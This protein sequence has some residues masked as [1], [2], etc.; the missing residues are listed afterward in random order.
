MDI[1]IEIVSTPIDGTCKWVTPESPV[2]FGLQRKDISNDDS[3]PAP[4]WYIDS[5]Q[6]NGGY[7]EFTLSAIDSPFSEGDSLML[8]DDTTGE[9]LY[10]VITEVSGADFLTDIVWVAGTDIDYINNFTLFPGYYFEA[11]LTINGVVNAL[12]AR[13]YPNSAG[14]ADMNIAG[15]LRTTILPGKADETLNINPEVNKSGRFTVSFRPCYY[16]SDE[17]YVEEGGYW[18]YASFVRNSIQGGNLLEYEGIFIDEDPPDD[19]NYVY[20]ICNQFEKPVFFKGLPF[21]LSFLLNRVTND[22]TFTVTIAIY[23]ATNTL[24]DT[25]SYEVEGSSTNS[26]RLCSAVISPDDIPDEAKYFDVEITSVVSV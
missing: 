23:D 11:L 2:L 13:A 6:D 3:S 10:G 25:I 26:S 9:E 5:T 16:G 1:E 18:S 12:T 4:D 8:H 17:S 19:F 15:V 24:I 14:Y 20:P 21:D 7:L 22:Q